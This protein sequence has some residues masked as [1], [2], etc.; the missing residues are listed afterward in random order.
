MQRSPDVFTRTTRLVA[1][2]LVAALVLWLL[3][4]LRFVLLLLV[5]AGWI[6]YALAP[7]V[8]VFSGRKRQFRPL[9]IAFAY[10][11]VI[12]GPSAVRG[13]SV[14]APAPARRRPAPELAAV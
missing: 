9:G 6:A 7:L 4:R 1:W 3:Y 11:T 13:R 14:A 10:L 2:V 8:H 12:G 5:A